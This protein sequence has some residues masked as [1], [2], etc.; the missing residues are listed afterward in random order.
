MLQ[1]EALDQMISLE[2]VEKQESQRADPAHLQQPGRS[3]FSD[4][5][6][7]TFQKFLKQLLRK[8][9]FNPAQ[10]CVGQAHLTNELGAM[11]VL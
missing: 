5:E 2:E 9:D 1:A 11:L 4:L 6:L 10:R 7:T 3:V 8:Q